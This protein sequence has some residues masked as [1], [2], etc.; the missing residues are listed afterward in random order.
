MRRIAYMRE[1]V[2]SVI[3]L[4]YCIRSGEGAVAIVELIVANPPIRSW[5]RAKIDA[6]EEGDVELLDST[7]ARMHTSLDMICPVRLNF[8]R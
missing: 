1:R 5:S 7:T 6:G 8:I 4:F 2:T 3:S